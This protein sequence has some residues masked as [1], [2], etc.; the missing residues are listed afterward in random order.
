MSSLEQ[1]CETETV[2]PILQME[3]QRLREG[4]SFHSHIAG[5]YKGVLEPRSIWSQSMDMGAAC[6]C[7]CCPEET[8]ETKAPTLAT[9][10]PWDLCLSPQGQA[11][12]PSL[13]YTVGGC[14]EK[15]KQG[16]TF[17]LGPPG[18]HL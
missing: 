8:E 1:P 5:A 11:E 13:G 14:S 12:P 2:A 15:A 6:T 4:K 3:K 9:H 7:V 10:T 17:R 16:L 18:L